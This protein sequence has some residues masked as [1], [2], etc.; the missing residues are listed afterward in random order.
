MNKSQ[1]QSVAVPKLDLS[2]ASKKAEEEMNR[3]DKPLEE[4]TSPEMKKVE[5]ML[6]RIV[7]KLE[8]IDESQQT[9]SQSSAKD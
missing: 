2:I 7:E 1:Q 9:G 5:E 6:Y 8:S 4:I 3:S